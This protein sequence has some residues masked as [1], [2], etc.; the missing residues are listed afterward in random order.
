MASLHRLV[1]EAAA[2]MAGILDAF[3]L[4]EIGVKLLD[5]VLCEDGI[6]AFLFFHG[7]YSL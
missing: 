4:F 7:P 5:A 3:V 1:R 6:P 2:I